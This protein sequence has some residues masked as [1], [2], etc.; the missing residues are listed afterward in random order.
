MCRCRHRRY[1]AGALWIEDFASA[2]LEEIR[3]HPLIRRGSIHPSIAHISNVLPK[4]SKGL[5]EGDRC[6]G[7]RNWPRNPEEKEQTFTNI[8]FPR[9]SR[10]SNENFKWIVFEHSNKRIRIFSQI[11]MQHRKMFLM[12]IEIRRHHLQDLCDRVHARFEEYDILFFVETFSF[13]GIAQPKVVINC[14]KSI[15]CPWYLQIDPLFHC[16]TDTKYLKSH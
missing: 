8:V 6:Q 12:I 1:P 4:E 7:D 13:W 16:V 2:L 14:Q 3:G 15:D 10:F 5:E 9:S 11:S